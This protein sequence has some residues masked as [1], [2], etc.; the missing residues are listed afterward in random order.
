MTL[1]RRLAIPLLVLFMTSCWA[2]ALADPN[3]VSPG[4]RPAESGRFLVH[5][6]VADSPE[7]ALPRRDAVVRQ[8]QAIGLAKET[9][10]RALAGRSHRVTREYQAVPFMAIEGGPDVRAAL[11]PMVATIYPDHLFRP[12]LNESVPLIRADQAWVQG[13]DGTGSV[14]AVLDTGVD[15]QHPFLA[16]K[17]I[18]EACYSGNGNCPNGTDTQLGPGAGVPCTFA[19][20]GCRHG[21]HVAGIAAGAGA[22][23]SGVARGGQVMAIQVFS[24]FTGT[25]C[26]GAGENPCALA[27]TS[28]LIAAMEHVY[29]F[30]AQYR[31]AAV[32]MSLGGAV[33]SSSA[34]CDADNAPTKAIIDTLRS[35]GIATVVAAGNN[36]ATNGIT[37]PACISSAISVGSTTKTDAISSFS[38]SAAFLSLLAPGSSI[39]SSVPGGG[40]AFFSGTS[41]ASPHVAGAWA[42]VKQKSPQASVAA[43]LDALVT[44]GVLRLDSRNGITKPRIDVAGAVALIQNGASATLTVNGSSTPITVVPG[45]IVTVGV[46]NGPGNPTDWLG[47]YQAGAADGAY[48]NWFYLNGTKSAPASGVTTASVPFTMPGIAGTY[49]FRLFANNGF[50]KLATSPTV[51]VQSTGGPSLTVNGS[52]AAITVAPG[53]TVTVGVQNGPGNRADWIGLYPAGALCGTNPWLDWFYLNGTKAYPSSGLQSA[54]VAFVMPATAGAYEFRFFL[55]DTCTKLATSSTVTVQ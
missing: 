1:R 15:K 45:A 13:F 55:N 44:T 38:N 47:L 54:T 7:G 50:T 36:G 31:I 14:V 23:F 33:Y 46:Q 34:Q 30:R 22:T 10:R 29:E 37:D 53:A 40:F 12:S 8:R 48:S 24:K 3:A 17:V 9:I 51:T 26:N 21:T 2:A 32:N 18:N 41:M 28:D 5:L 6:K 35:V 27:Y 11:A 49:E 42:V 4:S 19:P 20:G 52:S 25:D 39:L 16:G 43:V